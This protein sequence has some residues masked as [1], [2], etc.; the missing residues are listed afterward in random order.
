MEPV[1]GD[2]AN[3]CVDSALPLLNESKFATNLARLYR[4]WPAWDDGDLRGNGLPESPHTG[5]YFLTWT[6]TVSVS[7]T[8]PR[9]P[10][11]EDPSWR[12]DQ[13]LTDNVAFQVGRVTRNSN[14]NRVGMSRAADKN[15]AIRGM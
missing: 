9:G 3:E 4:T 10:K 2:R 1:C 8:E 12:Q 6:T 5:N 7:I 15:S 11:Q 14:W 13:P